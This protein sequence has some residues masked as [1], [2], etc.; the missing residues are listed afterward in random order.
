MS[1][2]GCNFLG[3]GKMLSGKLCANQVVVNQNF[4]VVLGLWKLCKG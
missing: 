2:A 1:Y 4:G 3:L